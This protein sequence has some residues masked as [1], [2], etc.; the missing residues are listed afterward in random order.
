MKKDQ[1]AK[2]SALGIY[3]RYKDYLIF[4]HDHLCLP[5]IKRISKIIDTD[6][7]PRLL[8]SLL[9][10]SEGLNE[11]SLLIQPE[12]DTEAFISRAILK[13]DIIQHTA[14]CNKPIKALV[15]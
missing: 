10:I 5:E 13:N 8:G 4:F 14:T 2:A 1:D 7:V 9:A 11:F 15:E 12:N 3:E 6:F